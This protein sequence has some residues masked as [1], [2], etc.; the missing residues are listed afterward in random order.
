MNHLYKNNYLFLNDKLNYKYD[1]WEIEKVKKR[2]DHKNNREMRSYARCLGQS[3]YEY[4]GWVVIGQ[5]GG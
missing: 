5:L 3:I 1:F 2:N 4:W